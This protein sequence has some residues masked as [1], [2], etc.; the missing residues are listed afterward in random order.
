MKC[1]REY[2][3]LGF[4]NCCKDCEEYKTELCKQACPAAEIYTAPSDKCIWAKDIERDTERR[5]KKWLIILL[6]AVLVMLAFALWQTASNV[7]Y[8]DKIKNG[9]SVAAEQSVS[10]YST[11]TTYS[12]AKIGGACND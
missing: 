1:P 9:Q 5:M 11:I 3:D 7:T 10:A 12:I 8:I 2:C 4:R 6:I